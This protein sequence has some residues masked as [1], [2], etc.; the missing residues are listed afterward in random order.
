MLDQKSEEVNNLF[1]LTIF[2]LQIF[3]CAC[4]IFCILVVCI[5]LNHTSLCCTVQRFHDGFRTGGPE[6]LAHQYM[7]FPP[8]NSSFVRLKMNRPASCPGEI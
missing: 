4:T 3:V 1:S 7:L 2:R 6:Q 8:D 5:L